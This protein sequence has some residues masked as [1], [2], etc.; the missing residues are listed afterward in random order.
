M[1]LQFIVVSFY[2]FLS[3]VVLSFFFLMIR[4]PPR[5][6]LFPYTTLFRS[7]ATVVTGNESALAA[8]NGDARPDCQCRRRRAIALSRNITRLNSTQTY[9][10]YAAFCLRKKKV[11]DTR[12]RM[13]KTEAVYLQYPFQFQKS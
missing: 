1:T 9:I 7:I 8:V 10:T 12:D 4:R 3:L 6:P 5:S 11:E 13:L 2:G